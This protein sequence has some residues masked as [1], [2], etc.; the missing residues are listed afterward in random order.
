MPHNWNDR[1]FPNHITPAKFFSLNVY[2]ANKTLTPE[3]LAY[4]FR[5]ARTGFWVK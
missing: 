3:A 1:S 5:A 2:N 4:Q